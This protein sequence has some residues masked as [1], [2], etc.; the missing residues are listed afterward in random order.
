MGQGQCKVHIIGK[1]AD[2]SVLARHESMRLFNALFTHFD[3]LDAHSNLMIELFIS[4]QP[5][6]KASKSVKWF[7]GYGHLKF[8]IEIQPLQV[9]KW[10][11][12]VKKYPVGIHFG[13][14]LLRVVA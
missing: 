12:S 14:K 6:V 10:D 1:R 7:Q 9:A 4:F 3:A 13:K 11:K 8:C 2:I 5:E